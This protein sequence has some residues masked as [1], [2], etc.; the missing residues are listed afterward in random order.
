MDGTPAAEL[1]QK[2]GA[3]DEA[4]LT[5]ILESISDGFYAL[6]RQWRYVIFNRA[7]EAYFGVTRD[8]LLGKVMWEVFPQGLGTPFEAACRA[9]MDD[10]VVSTFETPSRLR[11]DHT[12]E[13]RIAPM[14]G[15]GV[16]VVLNDISDRKAADAARELLMR[17]VDH[18][19]RNMMS[20]VQ[21]IVQLSKAPTL[22]AFRDLVLDRIGALGRAQ[23]TLSRRSWQG[24][25]LRQLIEE[26]MAT[27]GKAHAYAL[28]GPDITL[29]ADRVQP[30]GMIT[31]E[32]ATNAR[33]Y[34]AFSVETGEVRV[35]W[36]VLSG[37]ALTL[38]WTE[39]GGPPVARPSRRGFGSKLIGELSRGLGAEA[40][41]E[42]RPEGLAV[43][44]RLPPE[45]D[46]A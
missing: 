29:P 33:K 36:T 17:E 25:P 22:A 27:L 18:R 5:S 30:L 35:A 38:T 6:D 10:G 15:G 32:L 21:S 41:F 40:E 23:A 26:E 39:S 42:W 46:A 3:S 13:L 24:A 31:H 34:G 7:A 2:N 28:D 4:R 9:A 37:R 1:D 19:S 43:T 45:A 11:P 44:L 8:M 16:V 20:V 14:A 12:V